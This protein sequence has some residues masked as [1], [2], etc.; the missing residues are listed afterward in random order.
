MNEEMKL[1][2]KPFLM[3]DGSYDISA[4]RE[5]Y[6]G[7]FRSAFNALWDDEDGDKSNPD[8]DAELAHM[9][10][11][12]RAAVEHNE[13]LNT[14]TPQEQAEPEQIAAVI[15]AAIMIDGE[16]DKPAAQAALKRA[17]AKP[18]KVALVRSLLKR[19]SR[20][21][22][23]YATTPKGE[24]D[25]LERRFNRALWVLEEW[26]LCQSQDTGGYQDGYCDLSRAVAFIEGE[27]ET[28]HPLFN[29]DAS[30]ENTHR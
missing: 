4:V 5:A 17:D 14:T 3:E 9:S 13:T 10:E 27:A 30:E 6:P 12:W 8:I 7:N 26:G 16:F 23:D 22:A 11:E 28:S 19:I 1:K 18:V 20:F 25:L 15:E 29:S 21:E 2:L 24:R